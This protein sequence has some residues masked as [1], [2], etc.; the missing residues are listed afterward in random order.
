MLNN[1]QGGA[2]E[3]FGGEDEMKGLDDIMKKK[4]VEFFNMSPKELFPD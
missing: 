4:K 2:Q 1:K 3:T